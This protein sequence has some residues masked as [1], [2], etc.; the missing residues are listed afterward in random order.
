MLNKR[1]DYEMLKLTRIGWLPLPPILG[2]VY[3][4]LLEIG[5]FLVWVFSIP[6]V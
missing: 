3:D 4:I 5:R 2:G 1:E 6:T